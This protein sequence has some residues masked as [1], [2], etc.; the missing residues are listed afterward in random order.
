MK[1]PLQLLLHVVYCASAVFA[2][3]LPQELK[4]NALQL[5]ESP[6]VRVET[7]KS[8][9][10]ES[11]AWFAGADAWNREVPD[12]LKKMVE[13]GDASLKSPSGFSLLQV[14]AYY[15]DHQLAEWLLK[16]GADV[17]ARP[18]EWQKMGFPGETPLGLALQASERDKGLELVRLFLDKGADPD[19]PIMEKKWALKSDYLPRREAPLLGPFIPGEAK[20]LLLDYGE[21]DMSKRFPGKGLLALTTWLHGPGEFPISAAYVKKLMERGKF[22]PNETGEKG[23]TLLNHA[24]CNRNLELAELLLSKGADPN[25]IVR[26]YSLPPLFYLLSMQA[27]SAPRGEKENASKP[28]TLAKAVEMAK[29]LIKHGADVNVMTYPNTGESLRTHYGKIPGAEPIV[30]LLKQSGAR[31]YPEQELKK[32]PKAKKS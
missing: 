3:E 4:T 6:R 31:L 20:M 8:R 22:N 16:E 24:V 13:T 23:Y 5:A 10:C 30:E 7:I 27:I 29:L 15:G 11:P 21:Q 19:S 25:G 26:R 14:A 32:R 18:A 12:L 2:V 28:D 9:F 1:L 17:N